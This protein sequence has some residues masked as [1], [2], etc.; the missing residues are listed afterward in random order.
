MKIMLDECLALDFRHSFPGHEAHTVQWAG[1]KGKENVELLQANV[2]I[3]K[4]GHLEIPSDANGII[5]IGFNNHVRET[6]PQLVNRLQ[7]AGFALTPG[8]DHKS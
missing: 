7:N 8:G 6:V 1:L 2:V 5:Y 3:L 4:K